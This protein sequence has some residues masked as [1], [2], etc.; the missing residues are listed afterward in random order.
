MKDDM[1]WFWHVLTLAVVVWYSTTTI[2]V[3]IKGALDIRT[4]VRRLDEE[5]QEPG[6]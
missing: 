1:H 4:M 6:T 3:A 5:N 2:W